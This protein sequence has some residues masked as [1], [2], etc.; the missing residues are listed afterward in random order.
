VEPVPA[1]LSQERLFLGLRLTDGL[2]LRVL[3]GT[4]G[5]SRQE[6]IARSRSLAPFVAV[7]GERLRLTPRGALLSTSVLAELLD[8][9]V[10]SGEL[11]I[12]GAS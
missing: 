7:E 6:M 1:D 4:L 5:L 2:P 10:G 11:E 12:S 3:A 8:S 9:N